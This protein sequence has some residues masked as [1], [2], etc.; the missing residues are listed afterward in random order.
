[1]RSPTVLLSNRQIGDVNRSRVLRA[2][3]DHGPLSR[4]AVPG[5]CDPDAGRVVG[6]GP[7]PGAVGSGPAR[8]LEARFQLP[9]L[10]DNDARAQTSGRSGSAT[11]AVWPA[12]PRSRPAPASVWAWSYTASFTTERPGRPASSATRS[13]SSTARPATAG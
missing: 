3:C 10:V 6:S 4:A 13:C 11:A 7:L 1:V 5:V 9:V 2:L 12:S 8:A